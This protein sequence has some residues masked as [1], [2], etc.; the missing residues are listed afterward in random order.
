MKIILLTSIINVLINDMNRRNDITMKRLQ[1][2]SLIEKQIAASINK[3]KLNDNGFVIPEYKDVIS[4]MT[5]YLFNCYDKI[6]IYSDKQIANLDVIY[7]NIT[8]LLNT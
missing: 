8:N 4:A 1:R 7:Y 3:V 5:M 2:D 6:E